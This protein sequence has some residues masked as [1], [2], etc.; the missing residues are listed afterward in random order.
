[1][2]P[3]GVGNRLS[4]GRDYDGEVRD[5]DGRKED[6]GEVR[7]V[8]FVVALAGS[9]KAQAAAKRIWARDL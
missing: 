3:R 7:E 6:V 1:M 2:K 8:R 5:G 9:G 4:L